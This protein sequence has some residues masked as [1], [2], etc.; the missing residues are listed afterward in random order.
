MEQI[1][2]D[3]PE[4]SS[5]ATI[6]ERFWD[7]SLLDRFF[8]RIFI[9]LELVWTGKIKQN[10]DTVI[11]N[12]GFAKVWKSGSEVDFSSILRSLW[13]AFGRK[14]EP[15]SVFCGKKRAPERHRKSGSIF[16][17]FKGLSQPR[18]TQPAVPEALARGYKLLTL[19]PCSLVAADSLICSLVAL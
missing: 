9:V 2:K 16:M 18:E 8:H 11:K 4:K 15:W 10:H 7:V 5:E 17:D 6:L 14:L 19:Q 12:Q 1:F 13:Y 3:F